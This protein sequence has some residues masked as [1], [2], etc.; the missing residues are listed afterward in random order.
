MEILSLRDRSAGDSTA[1]YISVNGT[2]ECNGLEDVMREPGAGRPVEWE[3]LRAWVKSW[4]VPGRT[5][6]PFGRYQVIVDFSEHFK[7]E[8]AHILRVPGFDG[9]R[10]HSGL[11]PQDTEGCVLV[12]DEFIM[13]PE[14]W[15]V[16][17]GTTRPAAERMLEKIK[18]ALAVE[19][20]WW[21][22]KLNPNS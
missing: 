19:E 6:I 22:F 3:A 11:K 14:G 20:V 13:S 7:K 12:G 17:S 18:A 8:M 16:K 2:F 21:E 10:M 5:A 9:V 4:K 1:S 15:R